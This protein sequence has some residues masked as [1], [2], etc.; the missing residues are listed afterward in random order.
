MGTDKTDCAFAKSVLHSN[1]G[2]TSFSIFADMEWNKYFFKRRILCC[3]TKL[4]NK[5]PLISLH[6]GPIV[7]REAIGAEN[8]NGFRKKNVNFWDNL[9]NQFR[10]NIGC[11]RIFWSSVCH[12]GFALS[13]VLVQVAPPPLYIPQIFIYLTQLVHLGV[14]CTSIYSVYSPNYSFISQFV[15]LKIAFTWLAQS[16]MHKCNQNWWSYIRN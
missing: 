8:W 14:F 4:W 6:S 2:T 13:W 16:S 11:G 7:K 1:C 5:M 15:N 10:W 3:S 9:Q 12:S